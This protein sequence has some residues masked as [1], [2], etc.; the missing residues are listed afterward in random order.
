MYTLKEPVKI[1][2]K[3]KGVVITKESLKADQSLAELVLDNPELSIKYGHNFLFNGQP[4]SEKKEETIPV[5]MKKKVTEP[6]SPQQPPKSMPSAS[7]STE[8]KTGGMQ[9]NV[10]EQKQESPS[11]DSGQSKQMTGN[12]NSGRRR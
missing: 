3:N 5:T 11:K 4:V 6:E 9:L 12:Q 10:S 1:V 7:T 2:L 8:A